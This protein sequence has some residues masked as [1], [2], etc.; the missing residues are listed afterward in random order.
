[1]SRRIIIT[2]GTLWVLVTAARADSR[3]TD[4]HVDQTQ[5]RWERLAKQIWDTPELG[6]SETRPSSAL[7]G[8]LEKEGFHVTRGVGGIATAFVATAG[9]GTPIR[10]DDDRVSL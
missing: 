6:L 9:S 8:V 7:I 10:A 3:S 4:S 2:V 1:M 5:E